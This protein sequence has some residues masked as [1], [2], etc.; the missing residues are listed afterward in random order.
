[1]ALILTVPAVGWLL[2]VAGHPILM[3]GGFAVIVTVWT[4]AIA[5]CAA[6]HR[7]R[8]AT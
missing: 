8:H 3:V 5:G 2:L 6:V 4:I 7:D 1:M